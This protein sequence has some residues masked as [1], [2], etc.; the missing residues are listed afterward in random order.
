MYA[1]QNSQAKLRETSK[2]HGKLPIKILQCLE[3]LQTTQSLT[4]KASQRDH[5]VVCIESKEEDV[6]TLLSWKGDCNNPIT[7]E[8]YKVDV[9]FQEALFASISKDQIINL[10]EIE[11]GSHS[12][13]HKTPSKVS[14]A[15]PKPNSISA[16]N[17]VFTHYILHLVACY[18]AEALP[19][20]DIKKPHPIPIPYMSPFPIPIQTPPPKIPSTKQ[21]K[22]NIRAFQNPSCRREHK[23]RG[24]QKKKRYTWYPAFQSSR[25][26]GC[27]VIIFI[28]SDISFNLRAA[29]ST[30]IAISSDHP[31]SA[32][33]GLT[34]RLF[35]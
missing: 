22:K 26:V 9:T 3:N 25:Q 12:P 19:F 23:Q 10:S 18:F 33:T 14:S 24:T 20:S 21:K 29:P 8:K 2:H 13:F 28:V 31:R 35:V 7:V 16:S 5:V 4:G 17:V 1:L 15:T 27:T 34:M 30:A 6:N 11:E 32:I